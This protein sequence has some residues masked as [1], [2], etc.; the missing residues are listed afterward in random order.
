[1]SLQLGLFP[2][3]DPSPDTRAVGPAPPSQELLRLG[4]E[5]PEGLRLGTSS[6]SFPGWAGIVY[7]RVAS[8]RTL[9]KAGLPA[10]ARSPLFRTVGI[11][12]TYYR[13][14]TAE[15]FQ[16][17]AEDV[18][19]GFRFLVKADRRL[20][21]PTDPDAPGRRAPNPDYL[22]PGYA[23][24]EVVKPA[25]DGLGTKLGPIL[26]Q[27]SPGPPELFGGP[28]RFAERLAH[29]LGA[30]PSGPLYAVELRSP[31]L[32]TEHYA[33]TLEASGA[34]HGYTVHPAMPPLER[35]TTLVVPHYQPTLVIRWML[36]AGLRYE[37]AKGLYTPFDRLVDEDAATRHQIAIATLD[38]L[39]AEREAF[40]IANNKAEGSAPLTLLRL[41]D[42]IVTWRSGP[43][44]EA[45]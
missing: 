33:A 27:F 30:L 39:I 40:V 31:E 43:V 14:V 36:R 17:Y 22:E 35:Q 3:A 29:F 44:G 28:Q 42:H 2:D 11:D 37:A 16:A 9:A 12:R 15:V 1:M 20:T 19:D 41:A 34:A 8:E 18:P 23:T 25:M 7:D 32:L 24:R 21:S 10:Y 45:D 6:W 5:L 26:F 13:P 38:A 4:R